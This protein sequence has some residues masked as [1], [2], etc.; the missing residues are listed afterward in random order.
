[1]KGGNKWQILIKSV[2]HFCHKLTFNPSTNHQ[3]EHFPMGPFIF[4]NFNPPFL[5][6]IFGQLFT[7]SATEIGP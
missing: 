6:N 4:P 2:G 7:D 1:M 5:Y 3:L